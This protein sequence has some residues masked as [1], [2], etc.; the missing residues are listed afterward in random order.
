L[1]LISIAG[2]ATVTLATGGY[3][4]EGGTTIESLGPVSITQNSSTFA[5]L[6][7][8]D[9]DT[10]SVASIDEVAVYE[11][12]DDF[13]RVLIA[14]GSYSPG[15]GGTQVIH[16]YLLDRTEVTVDAYQACVTAGTCSVP[17]EC[18][19]TSNYGVPGRG[20]FPVNCVTLAQAGEYCA[21]GSGRLPNEWEWEWAARG[22]DDARIYPWGATAPDCTT[23]VM[24][25]GGDG[26]GTGTAADVA[27][28]SP[29]GDSRDGLHDMCGNVWEYMG[30]GGVRGGAF[31]ESDVSR[32]TVSHQGCS[33]PSD[34]GS[35]M[36]GFRCAGAKE[37][38]GVVNCTLDGGTDSGPPIVVPGWSFGL[39][40]GSWDLD[41][42]YYDPWRGRTGV[43]ALQN[44]SS[45][46]SADCV[47]M[48]QTLTIPTW[49]TTLYVDFSNEQYIDGNWQPNGTL[50]VMVDGAQ[51]ASWAPVAVQSRIEG[52]DISAYAGTSPN[53][54]LRRPAGP[55]GSVVHVDAVWIE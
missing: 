42:S 33:L 16:D 41:T 4:S 51:V 26:C 54:T 53:I 1:E 43:V 17:A 45:G 25:D 6:N 35:D 7:V 22:R 34:C 21:W 19:S 14:G 32:M 49:A 12:D 3:A 30:G 15:V 31:G 36:M 11:C 50:Q 29:N 52:A 55:G 24:D 37:C 28:R 20:Q 13:D 18:S 40:G 27:S 44:N 48:S 10:T 39:C 23:A 8:D 9:N 2:Q 47:E 38:G 46:G 5:R